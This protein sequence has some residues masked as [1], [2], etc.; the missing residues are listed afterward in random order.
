MKTSNKIVL[1]VIAAFVALLLV[2]SIVMRLN[3]GT[4]AANTIEN[5]GEHIAANLGAQRTISLSQKSEQKVYEVGAFSSITMVGRYDVIVKAG[6]KPQVQIVTDA[7]VLPVLGVASKS[8]TLSISTQKGVALNLP[9]PI[10]V[11]ITTNKLSELS[12]AGKIKLQ[13]TGI[14]VDKLTLNIAGKFDGTFVGR[15]KNLDVNV[16]GASMIDAQKL[17]TDNTHINFAGRSSLKVYVN[18]GLSINGFG[19]GDVAYYG[20]PRRVGYHAFG[21]VH[22]YRAN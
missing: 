18:K 15:A 20:N 4:N 21:K 14:K 3:A 6:A 19:A 10:K 22:V 7:N 11:I 2:L 9:T 17:I 8:G 1:Y 16:G 13:A 5:Y 12:V